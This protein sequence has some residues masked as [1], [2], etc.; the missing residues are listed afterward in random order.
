MNL[1]RAILLCTSLS[2][3][4]AF[5]LITPNQ[6]IAAGST[7]YDS[8]AAGVKNANAQAVVYLKKGVWRTN[9]ADTEMIWSIAGTNRG[10]MEIEYKNENIKRG[11]IDLINPITVTVRNA[12]GACTVLTFKHIEYTGTGLFSGNS[13][14][15]IVGGAG[16]NDPDGMIEI[17]KHLALT[18]DAARFFRGK[19]F[20]SLAPLPNNVT[21]S[22]PPIEICA[23]PKCTSTQADI[24]PITLIQLYGT[25]DSNG[26]P[27]QPFAVDFKENTVLSLGTNNFLQLRD[28][29]HVQV[30][31]LRYDLV[32]SRGS[33]TLS[34]LT[35]LLKGG[36]LSAGHTSINFPN[37]SKIKFDDVALDAAKSSLTISRGNFDGQIASGSIINLN[38]SS[39]KLSKLVLDGA[40]VKL[41]GLSGTFQGTQQSLAAQYGSLEAQITSADLW[42]GASSEVVLGYTTLRLDLGC[43]P[44]SPSPSCLPIAWSNQGTSLSGQITAFNS[45]ITAGQF[46]LN[47]L[48]VIR[49]QGG[50]IKAGDLALDTRKKDEPITGKFTEVSVSASSQDLLLDTKNKIKFAHIDLTSNDLEFVSNDTYPIGHL[51]IKG[52]INGGT[53]DGLGDIAVANANAKLDSVISRTANDEI[54]VDT[55]EVSGSL[56]ILYDQS[57]VGNVDFSL[58]DARY[59]HGQG[60]AKLSMN[61]HDFTY[62]LR[63]P[64]GSEHPECCGDLGFKSDIDIK[65]FLVQFAAAPLNIDAE[66]KAA[67]GT[68]TIKPTHPIPVTAQVHIGEQL[69]VDA[70]LRSKVGST[71]ICEPLLKT[72]NHD[73]TI[74]ATG[75]FSVSS[76]GGNVSVSGASINEGLATHIDNKCDDVAKVLCGIIGTIISGNPIGGAAAAIM[77]GNEVSKYERQATDSIRD[78]SVEEVSKLHYQSSF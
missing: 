42:F 35:A 11:M 26:N 15:K 1:R 64:S 72:D 10:R 70:K 32:Q 3:A 30:S 31:Q 29:S 47:N 58:K 63:T 73:Y 39:G 5:S 71:L 66:V 60:D 23:D 16:C 54:R 19:V 36:T 9:V 40:K 33:A 14:L 78:K 51:T 59:Y 6:A 62:D 49:L 4:S 65:S 57:R 68:W 61:A 18:N 55:A 17:E 20:T 52:Q 48:G 24:G 53:M 22:R 56:K 77:C 34:D 74:V 8:L 46:G 43:P 41:L 76:S 2:T 37:G 12:G 67:G 25:A 27:L 69:G 44:T 45:D 21:S 75:N 50:K 7:F 28:G 13:D 38:S